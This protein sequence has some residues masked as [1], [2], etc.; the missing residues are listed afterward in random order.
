MEKVSPA[1]ETFPSLDDA[2]HA[3]QPQDNEITG[4]SDQHK[5]CYHNR[6]QYKDIIV[7]LY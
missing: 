3:P 7:Y 4:K 1:F 6:I 5:T 2:S